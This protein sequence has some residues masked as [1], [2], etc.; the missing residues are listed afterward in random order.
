M[1]KPPENENA[2]PSPIPEVLVEGVPHR[3]STFPLESP[4]ASDDLQE[5]DREEH[6]A[7]P[8]NDLLRQFKVEGAN[9]T[10]WPLK[11]LLRILSRERVLAELKSYDTVPD[12][13]ECLNAVRPEDHHFSRPNVRTYLRTFALLLLF[14][15]GEE[16]GKFVDEEVSDQNLPVYCNLVEN[17]R[18][19]QLNVHHKAMSDKP[20]VCFRDWKTHEKEDF[21]KRQW[22]FLIPYLELESGKVAKHYTFDENIILPWLKRQG[23]SLSST[24]PSGQGGGFGSVS[25][26]KID[27]SSHGFSDILQK[28]LL[29]K[30]D[31]ENKFR[32][33]MEQLRRFNGSAHPHLVTL[34]STFTFLDKYH[35]VFP[36]ADSTLE[37][38][39]EVIEPNPKMDIAT[40]RWVSR[41][42]L[43][44]VGA[45]AVIHDPPHLPNL[46]VD[47]KRYGRHG[48]IKPD[49]ILWFRSSSDDKG[50]LV[51]TDLGLSDIHREQ[52]KSG[53]PRYN[54]A[55]VPGYQPPECDL[56]QD[57]WAAQ[58]KPQVTEWF[59]S[60]HANEKCPQFIHDAL[61]IIEEE[62]L[63]VLYIRQNRTPSKKLLRD[64]TP[65]K[66][67][68]KKFDEMYKKCIND[69]NS[70][71]Y[72]KGISIQRPERKGTMV[73]VD[74]NKDAKEAVSERKSLLPI[75]DPT[76]EMKKSPLPKDLEDMDKF[77]DHEYGEGT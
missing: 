64:R 29:D 18:R 17:K 59:R 11:R 41:Q 35:F 75:Y 73:E 15:R 65:S 45:V 70:D 24:Q 72:L 54:I 1:Y 23:V 33:E 61:K 20:L 22:Q 21:E 67:L 77:P 32:K 13:D 8:L 42:I 51:V 38:Y 55:K 25:T 14:E 71:Y 68:L 26:I 47:S 56:G 44:L 60:L 43:G 16:I 58:V 5:I 27:P 19:R 74:L 62:M 63:I 40:V 69:S 76:G 52:S 34:L 49:N 6:D 53:I 28:V 39:W 7:T 9:G 48:D 46:T 57:R 66:G 3:S 12:P 4:M 10:F 36:Y 37:Y 2:P 30:I 31:N 50:I